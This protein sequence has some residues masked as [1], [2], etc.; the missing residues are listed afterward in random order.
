MSFLDRFF[1]VSARNS[2]VKT[3]IIA[4]LTTF[5]TMAY[6][7]FVQPTILSAGGM[8]FGAVL[9]ATCISSAFASILMGLYANYP[10]A[11]APAM[12]EN[13]FFTFSVIVAMQISWQ[14]A[15]GII[16]ISGVLFLLLTFFNV[17]ELMINAIPMSLKSGIAVGIGIF[18]A[19]IGL[20]YGGIIVKDPAGGVVRLGDVKSL[21]VLLPLIGLLIIAVLS[22]LRVKGAMIIGMAII[23]AIALPYGIVT[24]HGVVSAPPSIMP[25]L[26][27]MNLL[28]A[29]SLKY[30]PL[31]LVF[32]FMTLFDTVGTVVGV[33]QQAGLMKEDGSVPKLRQILMTDAT[34]TVVGAALG[35]STVVTYIESSAGVQEGGRTGLTAI[36]AGVMFILALFFE[37]LAKMLGGGFRPDGSQLTFYPIIAPA[38]IFVGAMLMRSV[39]KIDFY[40]LTESLPA[41]LVIVGMPLTYSIADGLAFGFI[42]YPILKIFTGRVKEVHW[43]MHALAVIFIL[44]YAFL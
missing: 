30:L 33:T 1:Q 3:E 15:L 37:P 35:T 5:V 39:T 12:G 42:S 43:M 8:D 36:V 16:F 2:S 20:V 19:F 21:H 4:G 9:A 32:L 10:I 24:F 13:I 27:Q 38:L 7:I 14:T 28:D 11:L 41:F 17:R 34:A 22:Y 29:L 6:I 31:I 18:I 44:R 26:F 40:D 25:T 23:T